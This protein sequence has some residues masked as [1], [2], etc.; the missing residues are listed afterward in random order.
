MTPRIRSFSS[1]DGLSS[2]LPCRV[3]VVISTRPFSGTKR[4]GR[5]MPGFRQSRKIVVDHSESASALA[6][7]EAL[8]KR[9]APARGRVWHQ[10][11]STSPWAPARGRGSGTSPWAV[12]YL[13]VSNTTIARMFEAGLLPVRQVVPYAPWKIRRAD[14]DSEP[15]RGVVERLKATGRLD[16]E[17]PGVVPDHSAWATSQSV[18]PRSGWCPR[19]KSTVDR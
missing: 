11:V 13:S 17:I 14:L 9:L 16:L 2:S 8:K 5:G 18:A 19:A 7:Q 6:S 12:W 10:P 4:S 3:R 15:V 1:G